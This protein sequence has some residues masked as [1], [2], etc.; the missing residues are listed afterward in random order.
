M[1][2]DDNRIAFEPVDIRA[3]PDDQLDDIIGGAGVVSPALTKK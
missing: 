1:D 3:I 2:S